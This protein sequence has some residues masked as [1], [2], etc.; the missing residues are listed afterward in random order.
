MPSGIGFFVSSWRWT[1]RDWW[2]FVGGSSTEQGPGELEW[3]LVLSESQRARDGSALHDHAVHAM[4]K[5]GIADACLWA[6]PRN[7]PTK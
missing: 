2:L 3:P 1:D 5:A 6:V 7:G 4:F